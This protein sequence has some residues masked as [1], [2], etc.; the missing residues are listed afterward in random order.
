MCCMNRIRPD[1]LWHY[2]S[3]NGFLGIWKRA[4]IWASDL[5]FLNDASENTRL[6]DLLLQQMRSRGEQGYKTFNQW[7][8]SLQLTDPANSFL[9][10]PV[11][12]NMTN[13]LQFYT[14]RLRTSGDPKRLSHASQVCLTPFRSGGHMA[15][16]L[17]TRSVSI[18]Y[19]CH[20]YSSRARV[21][22]RA[23]RHR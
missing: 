1:I 20:N 3:V 16:A 14:R 18:P 23:R 22:M 21:R 7:V 5:R 15:Q 19:V 6:K 17:D 11:E 12:L 8:E 13:A 9:Y 10:K 2:T 4:T